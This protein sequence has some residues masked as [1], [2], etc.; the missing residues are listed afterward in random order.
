MNEEISQERR[1]QDE[2]L[3]NVRFIDTFLGHV[4]KLTLVE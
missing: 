1:A 4:W 2:T 3:W